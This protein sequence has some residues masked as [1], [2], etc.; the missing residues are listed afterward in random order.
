[1]RSAVRRARRRRPCR[2]ASVA[3]PDHLSSSPSSWILRVI[4]LRPMP[5]FCAASMRRPRVSLERGADQLRLELARQ[6]VPDHRLARLQ[7]LA[8]VVARGRR[9]SRGRA[10]GRSGTRRPRPVGA[11]AAA[12]TGRHGSVRGASA[13]HRRAAAGAGATLAGARRD[14]LRCDCSSGGRSL[15]STSCAGAITVSQWQMFSSWRTLPG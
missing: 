5:S 3:A 10:T 1:M 15:A 2:V 6:R 8:C 12:R 9:A 13:A 7:Q 4:V 14:A 11:A